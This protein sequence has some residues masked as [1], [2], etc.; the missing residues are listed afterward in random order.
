MPNNAIYAGDAIYGRVRGVID[1]NF[2]DNPSK[3]VFGGDWGYGII[4]FGTASSA[5]TPVWNQD[6]TQ[7]L[8][9]YETAPAGIPLVYIEDNTFYRHR[10]AIASNQGTWYVARYNTFYEPRPKNYGII[11]VHGCAG[12]G[13]GGGRGLEAYNNII[14]GAVGYSA[15]QAFW[16][17]GGGGAVFNNEIT[18]CL[19]G[20]MLSAREPSAPDY[21]QIRDLWIWS[22]TGA[23]FN[24]GDWGYV[25]GVDY[26]LRAPTLTEDGFTYTP[27]PYP[28]PLTV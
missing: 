23:P 20:V 24:P 13:Y 7:F 1:H 9:K 22:N 4:V 2:F 18:G 27:Y 3:D 12:T 15:S 25:E 17:R 11:D 28:H 14:H 21:T 8:G 16:L 6:I 10:H 5:K 26:F 19:Y